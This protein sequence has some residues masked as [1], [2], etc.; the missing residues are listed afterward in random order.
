MSETTCQSSRYFLPLYC[1]LQLLNT[2]MEMVSRRKMSEMRWERSSRKRS[3]GNED[4]EENDQ[5]LYIGSEIFLKGTQSANPHNDYQQHFVD[6][7]QSDV[8]GIKSG[9]CVQPW[10]VMF[11]RLSI[12]GTEVIFEVFLLLKNGC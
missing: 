3:R 2:Q 9:I 4:D 7:G 10:T 12:H 1:L 6:T 5:K 11:V 8:T